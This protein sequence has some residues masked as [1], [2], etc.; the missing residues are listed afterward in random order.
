MGLSIIILTCNQKAFT[1]RVLDSLRDFMRQ[2]P[3]A[4]VIIVD[5]GSTDGT[6]EAVSGRF[7]DWG[8]RLIYK[9]LDENRGVA[10][11][12]NVGLS[13]ARGEALMI[14]DNDTVVNAEAL[15]HL[16][17]RLMGDES[18]GV[19]APALRSPE[20]RLQESAKPYPGL[21]IKLRHFISQ[22]WH[23]ADEA[24]A[25]RESEPCYVIGA[26]QMFRRS[27]RQKVGSLDEGIFY[28]PEDADFCMRVRALG[29]RILYDPSVGI[30]HDWQRATSSRRFTRLSFLHIRALFHLYFKYRR[31]F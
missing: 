7:R 10:A 18:I 27:T 15:R 23:R 4:E 14:L 26:C 9:R 17:D 11:G 28:G 13:L 22:R 5:N 29:L 3:D 19:I 12:R 30:I 24:A 31:F 8:C 16:Y 1:L 6:Q 21:G 2:E 20:G 25:P